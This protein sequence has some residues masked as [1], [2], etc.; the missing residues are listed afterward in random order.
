MP[1]ELEMVLDQRQLR[2][3]VWRWRLIAG[4]LALLGLGALAGLSHRDDEAGGVFGGRAQIARL[5]ITGLITEDRAQIELLKK[6]GDDSAV[7]AVIL[8]I[9]SPGGTTTGFF[10]SSSA[11][12]L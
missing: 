10:F 5:D 4:V 11:M 6:L 8:A 7:K 2:S 1:S 12:A 9:D 3:K